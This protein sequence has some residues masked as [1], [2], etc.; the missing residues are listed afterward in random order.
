MSSPLHPHLCGCLRPDRGS[1]CSLPSISPSFS[2]RQRL[3]RAAHVYLTGLSFPNTSLPKISKTIKGVCRFD[4]QP[5]YSPSWSE[6]LSAQHTRTEQAYAANAIQRCW[7]G[8]QGRL[9]AEA[10]RWMLHRVWQVTRKFFWR[11]QMDRVSRCMQAWKLFVDLPLMMSAAT[12]VQALS[13]RF[14]TRLAYF[15]ARQNLRRAMDLML[16][17]FQRPA[18]RRWRRNSE[19]IWR[20]QTLQTYF[21]RLKEY[22]RLRLIINECMSLASSRNRV[23]ALGYTLEHW[24]AYA[25]WRQWQEERA[26]YEITCLRWKRAVQ[27]WKMERWRRKRQIFTYLK[28]FH[29]LSVAR[30]RRGTASCR[31]QSVWR[32]HHRYKIETHA[33]LKIQRLWRINARAQFIRRLQRRATLRR[34]LVKWHV[35]VPLLH[36]LNK[37]RAKRR[38]WRRVVRRRRRRRAAG[39]EGAPPAFN[40]VLKEMERQLCLKEESGGS[41]HE[42]SLPATPSTHLA[43]PKRARLR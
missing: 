11:L 37:R 43:F 23:T 27:M 22:T 36:L 39:V 15:R 40:N 3:E 29:K 32:S 34:C 17:G 19:A 38:Q 6:R 35:L 4:A 25:A 24:R 33:V 13:R 41:T 31:I 7:R 14:L 30:S 16:S 26:R 12:R 10:R 9:D 18:F 8:W 42:S 1:T 21:Q 20:Y 2:N 28:M 5:R